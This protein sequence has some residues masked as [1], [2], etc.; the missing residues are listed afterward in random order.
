[1]T[2]AREERKGSRVDA[3]PDAQSGEVA[4]AWD[5]NAVVFLLAS[6]GRIPKWMQRDSR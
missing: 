2:D 1:M 4:D 3:A 6:L 5:L